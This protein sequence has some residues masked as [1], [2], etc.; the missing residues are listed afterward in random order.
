VL[1]VFRESLH[2]SIMPLAG[3]GRKALANAK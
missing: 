2:G 3:K 1:Q